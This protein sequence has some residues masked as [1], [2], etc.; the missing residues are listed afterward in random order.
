[1]LS[2]CHAVTLSVILSYCHHNCIYT[3]I[4]T[5]T[6]THIH[7][8][9][10]TSPLHHLG[11]FYL[12]LQPEIKVPNSINREEDGLEFFG[13]RAVSL[14]IKVTNLINSGRVVN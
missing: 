2:H 10:I 9:V 11:T 14:A 13:I 3:H 6:Y 4:Y 8:D 12:C 5:H 7:I 1:M